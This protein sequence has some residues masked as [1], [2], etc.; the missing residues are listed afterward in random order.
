MPSPWQGVPRCICKAAV[1]AVLIFVRVWKIS[2]DEA[3]RERS[4]VSM[5]NL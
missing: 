1:E 5:I 4:D 2:S 3:Y